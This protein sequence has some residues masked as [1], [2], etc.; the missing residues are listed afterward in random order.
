MSNL[1]QKNEL[2]QVDIDSLVKGKKLTGLMSLF[3]YNFGV[4]K[5]LMKQNNGFK[6]WNAYKNRQRDYPFGGF[7]F[8]LS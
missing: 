8:I 1:K 6:K 2:T 5:K 3:F 7:M 4:D